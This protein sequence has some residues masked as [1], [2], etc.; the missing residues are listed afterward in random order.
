MS[1]K[2]IV[3]NNWFVIKKVLICNWVKYVDDLGF[4][5]WNFLNKNIEE[6]LNL[7]K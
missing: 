6:K 5:N 3:L 2:W 7:I 1:N 4:E